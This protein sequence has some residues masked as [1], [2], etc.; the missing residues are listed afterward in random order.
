MPDDDVE[1]LAALRRRAY[2][3]NADIDGDAVAQA[4]LAELELA[5]AVARSRET[6]AHTTTVSQSR[7]EG[8]DEPETPDA[9]AAVSADQPEP[10]T[11]AEPNPRARESSR[12]RRLPWILAAIAGIAALIATLAAIVSI[13][14]S[15]TPVVSLPIASPPASV[16]EPDLGLGMLGFFG[17]RRATLR[18]HGAV[19]SLDVWTVQGRDSAQCVVLSLRGEIWDQDCAPRPLPAVLDVT[20]DYGAL[21]SESPGIDMPSGSFVRFAWQGGAVDLYVV[22]GTARF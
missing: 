4:R 11:P 3:P 15:P 22:R 13:E 5:L 17:A 6:P 20:A 7:G 10:A 19:G 2:G 16:R 12:G 1:E 9:S 21:H 18:Y 8:S 14:A